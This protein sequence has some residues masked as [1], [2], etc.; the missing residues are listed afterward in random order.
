MVDL[1][2]GLLI[3]FSFLIACGVIWAMLGG[4]KGD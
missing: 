3:I 4:F 2:F 1:I